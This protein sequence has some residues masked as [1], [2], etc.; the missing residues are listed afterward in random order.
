MFER[1]RSKRIKGAA[2]D[3]FATEPLPAGHPLWGL[4]NV[5]ITPHCSAVYDGW[6]V[7][8]GALFAD[9]LGRYAPRRA[10]EE[11]RRPGA[12]LL[13]QRKGAGMSARKDAAA[14][15]GS[16]SGPERRRDPAAAVADA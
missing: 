1:L 7:K 12:G 8:I 9:N 3:V 11:C 5:I 2:L 14:G 4:D 13:K 15:G 16:K 10:L 6:E